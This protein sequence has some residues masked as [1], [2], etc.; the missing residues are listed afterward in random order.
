MDEPIQEFIRNALLSG[1]PRVDLI[2][3]VAD[4]ES[5]SYPEAEHLVQLGYRFMIGA[6]ENMERQGLRAQLIEN[7]QKAL[8]IA[9]EDR[10]PSAVATLIGHLAKLGRLD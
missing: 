5:C 8:N 6:Y 10:Q 1:H 9:M 7:A 2:L 3:Q 4:R